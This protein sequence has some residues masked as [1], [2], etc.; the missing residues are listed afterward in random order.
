MAKLE[1]GR[2]V[3]S[4]IM[5]EEEEEE[6]E[7]AQPKDAETASAARVDTEARRQARITAAL[8]GEFSGNHYY[9]V[10]LIIL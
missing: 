3:L 5:S 2:Q 10:T 1:T 7:D 6:D 4:R 8:S 9:S